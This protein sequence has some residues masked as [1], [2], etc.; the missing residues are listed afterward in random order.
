MKVIRRDGTIKEAVMLSQTDG[1]I[2]AVLKGD[3]DVTEFVNVHGT[4]V[5]EDCEPVRIE[6]A[7]EQIEPKPIPTEAECICSKEL[8]ARLIHLLVSGGESIPVR[9]RP[10]QAV[11][12]LCSS[13]SETAH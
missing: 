1:T 3:D 2:R 11:A 12:P 13:P 9:T 7:W 10:E 5:C 6:F 4:W 8:A